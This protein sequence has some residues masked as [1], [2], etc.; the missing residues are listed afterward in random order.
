MAQQELI[1]GL[2]AMTAVIDREP[3]RWIELF[4][5]KGR[6]DERLAYMVNESRRHDI[7]ICL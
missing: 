6:E 4:V 5:L 2:H 1:Y 3:E 7:G